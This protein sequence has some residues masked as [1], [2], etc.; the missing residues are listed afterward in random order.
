MT[1]KW[2]FTSRQPSHLNEVIS[3]TLGSSCSPWSRNTSEEKFLDPR[4]LQHDQRETPKARLSEIVQTTNT[5]TP[6]QHR[7]SGHLH[8]DNIVTFFP[9]TY[10]VDRCARMI[11][12]LPTTSLQFFSINWLGQSHYSVWPIR[13]SHHREEW[14]SGLTITIL[15]G[16]TRELRK[17]D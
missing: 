16:A 7:L 4:P 10:L 1:A 14:S 15:T 5:I 11:A 3:K 2:F 6:W 12:M 13:I 17:L 9:S 8:F